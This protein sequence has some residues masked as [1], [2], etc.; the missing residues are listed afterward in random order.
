MPDTDK[1]VGYAFIHQLY[2]SLGGDSVA[3]AGDVA[4]TAQL[5]GENAALSPNNMHVPTQQ[6]LTVVST[7]SALAP[8]PL[9][10]WEKDGVCTPRNSVWYINNTAA[11]TINAGT[12]FATGASLKANTSYSVVIMQWDGSINGNTLAVNSTGKSLSFSAD[13]PIKAASFVVFICGE[14]LD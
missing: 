9:P 14:Y 5:K 11:Y 1:S 2:D 13:Q 8:H 10:C 3:L 12:V 4:Y 6:N 7:F